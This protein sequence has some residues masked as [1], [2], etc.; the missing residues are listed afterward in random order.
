MTSLL[1]L[2]KKIQIQSKSESWTKD[3]LLNH[4]VSKSITVIPEKGIG[5]IWY[6][7]WR[8]RNRSFERTYQPR[9]RKYF[10]WT[11]CDTSIYNRWENLIVDFSQFLSYFVGNILYKNIK[12]IMKKTICLMELVSILTRAIHQNVRYLEDMK[13]VLWFLSMNNFFH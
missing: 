2:T 10:C 1:K 6:L 8:D 3:P 7:N 11:Q 4:M 5:N 12:I 13:P 9:K